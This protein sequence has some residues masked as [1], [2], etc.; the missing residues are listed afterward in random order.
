MKLNVDTL[1]ALIRWTKAES[2]ADR[3]WSAWRASHSVRC[4]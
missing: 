1:D 4:Q 2:F 3:R